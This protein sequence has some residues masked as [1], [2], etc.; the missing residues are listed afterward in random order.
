V[1]YPSDYPV[2]VTTWNHGPSLRP[3]RPWY[4]NRWFIVVDIAFGIAMGFA[5]GYLA[6]R[7][8]Q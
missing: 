7:I 4:A 5:L 2:L 8:G 6:G 3:P 1:N